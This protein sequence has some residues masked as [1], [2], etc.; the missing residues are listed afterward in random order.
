[1]AFILKN[2]RG[3]VLM[4]FARDGDDVVCRPHIHGNDDIYMS[5][6]T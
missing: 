5:E 1:V 6:A 4:G 3:Y 2:E